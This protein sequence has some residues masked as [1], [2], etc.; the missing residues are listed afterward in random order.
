LLP[1]QALFFLQQALAQLS[2]LSLLCLWQALVQLCEHL[3]LTFQQLL[4]L[5]R[6]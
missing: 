5:F 1:A 4:P 6:Q 3:A 2:F